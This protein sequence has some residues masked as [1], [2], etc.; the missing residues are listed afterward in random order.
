MKTTILTGILSAFLLIANG[1]PRLQ[2]NGSATQLMVND[3]PF[4]VLGGELYNSSTSSKAFMEPLWQ[5]L[6]QQHLNTVLAAVSWELIEPQEGKFD[7]SLVDEILKGARAQN[8]KVTLLWFGS[9][10]NGLSHYTPL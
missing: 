5:P 6:K 9:W 4:L 8:L 3:K 10:K 2:K 7:F 1:Q